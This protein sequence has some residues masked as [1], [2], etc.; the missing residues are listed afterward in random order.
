MCRATSPPPTARATADRPGEQLLKTELGLA[1]TSRFRAEVYGA[2]DGLTPARIAQFTACAGEPDLS[3]A[4][5]LVRERYRGQRVAGIVA[6]VRR[7]RHG[8]GRA[9]SSVRAPAFDGPPVFADRRRI[10]GRPA[11]PGSA[12]YHRRRSPARSGVG[13]PARDGVQRGFGRAPFQIRVLANGQPVDGR[14]RRAARGRLARR[15]GLHR[16]AR[17]AEPDGLYRRDSRPTTGRRWPRTTARSVLV[18]PAGRKRTGAARRGAPGF[19]HSFIR[20]ALAGDPVL[21]VDSVVRKGRTP[22]ARTRSSCRRADRTR[23]C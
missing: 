1:L 13:G 4:L 8:T 3:G 2:G 20:R 17:S 21:D 14:R 19:E 9:G 22:T 11:R 10:A 12:R 7:R 5:C 16:L 6:A 23:R 18:N 15:R